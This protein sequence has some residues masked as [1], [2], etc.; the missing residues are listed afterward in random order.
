MDLIDEKDLR[1]RVKKR[2]MET[3]KTG[4]IALRY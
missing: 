1:R 4:M 2:M 3:E